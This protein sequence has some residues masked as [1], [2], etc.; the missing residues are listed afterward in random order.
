MKKTINGKRYDTNSA[1]AIGSA[2]SPTAS[3]AD[4]AYWEATLYKSPRAGR[5]FLAGK[6]GPM[7]R[8]ARPL[9]GNTRTGGEAIIPLE[10]QEAFEW[11]QQY[12]TT[13]E[14]ETHFGEMIE[15]A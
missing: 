13:D 14:V 5:Y 8:F 7:T 12:L 2:T 6:G 3:V 15:D 1:I 10:E 11:A 9:D 4:F